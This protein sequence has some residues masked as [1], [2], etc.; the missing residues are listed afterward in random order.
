M[1]RVSWL[2]GNRFRA[3]FELRILK[4]A[5]F[6]SSG[7]NAAQVVT[8][9]ADVGTRLRSLEITALLGKDG[10]RVVYRAHDTKLGRDVAIKTLPDAFA[11]DAS[12]AAECRRP[13][14]G[15]G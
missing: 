5:S 13:S 6:V 14:A 10:M 1:A 8:M 2:D 9:S 4:F 12:A 11:N 7:H 3:L 15:V